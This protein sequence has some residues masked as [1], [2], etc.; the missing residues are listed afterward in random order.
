MGNR[1]SALLSDCLSRVS[2]PRES[3]RRLPAKPGGEYKQHTRQSIT[4]A[5]SSTSTISSPS[6]GK[7]AGTMQDVRMQFARAPGWYVSHPQHFGWAGGSSAGRYSWLPPRFCSRPPASRRR[8]RPL[9]APTPTQ[10][11]RDRRSRSE[12]GAQLCARPIRRRRTAATAPSPYR[13]VFRGAPG[14][15]GRQFQAVSLPRSP[16]PHRHRPHR[17][18]PQPETAVVGRAVGVGGVWEILISKNV[19]TKTQM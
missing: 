16:R 3:I 8:A 9:S 7:T 1:I 17:R 13:S 10:R 11:C 19:E 6:Q 4:P 12:D 15:E 14:V 2:G 5:V 18:P